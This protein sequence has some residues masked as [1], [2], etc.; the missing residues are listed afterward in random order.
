MKQI[1]IITFVL[2]NTSGFSQALNTSHLNGNQ[3]N[4]VFLN[5]GLE[6]GSVIN[7]G[8]AR[9][10]SAL[11][12][13][14]TGFDLTIPAGEKF[15]DDYKLKAIIQMEILNR[16]NVRLTGTLNPI[17]RCLKNDLYTASGLA[18]EMGV[19]AGYYRPGWYVA[20]EFNIDQ[21]ILTHI[22]HSNQYKE[23][24]PGAQ[25]GWYAITACNFNYGLQTGF[26]IGKTGINIRAGL[27]SDWKFS[28]NT[29]PVYCLF[30]ISRSF[31]INTKIKK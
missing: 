22:K 8:Y 28:A 16:N 12:K 26:N 1:I 5:V 4:L 29:L 18:G 10:F 13:L 23:L 3:K 24:F 14:I 20:G 17:F 7:L 9:S 19:I 2:L 27:S 31:Q 30:G 6:Y 11:P 15:F 21:T 25:S